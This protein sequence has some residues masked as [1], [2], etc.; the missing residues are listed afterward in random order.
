MRLPHSGPAGSRR[1]RGAGGWLALAAILM[2]IA[3]VLPGPVGF[4]MLGVAVVA[5]LLAGVFGLRAQWRTVQEEGAL[6]APVVESDAMATNA[7]AELT[8][9]LRRL[10]EEHV[11][12]VDAALDERRPDVARELNDAYIDAALRAITDAADVPA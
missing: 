4:A 11:A 12:R 9:Q 6:I 1:P 8:A 2:A 3:A 10:R 5:L 7:A